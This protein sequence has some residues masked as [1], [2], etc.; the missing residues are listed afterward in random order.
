MLCGRVCE[1]GDSRQGSIKCPTS[2]D[3]RFNAVETLSTYFHEARWGC[4]QR[5]AKSFHVSRSDFHEHAIQKEIKVL[6]K[7]KHHN[8]IQLY[9][10]HEQED[11]IHQVMELAEKGTLTK[12]NTLDWPTKTRIAH[13]IARGLEYIRQ[14]R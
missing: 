10:T 9:R 1:C 7:F 3:P 2:Q 4:Q 6:K 8:I 11:R 14:L 5:A 12:A 13:E